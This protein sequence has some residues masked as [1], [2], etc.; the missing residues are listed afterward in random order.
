MYRPIFGNAFVAN[1][2]TSRTRRPG[3][4]KRENAY[5]A[6]RQMTADATVTTGANSKL[7]RIEWPR[8]LSSN[9][10]RHHCSV[11]SLGRSCG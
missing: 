10:E 7:S 2:E 11:H 1:S 3:K 6:G 8:F 5:A 9:T 4:L